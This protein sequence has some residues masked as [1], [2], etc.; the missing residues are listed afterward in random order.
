MIVDKHNLY[1]ERG[2]FISN[3]PLY[4]VTGSRFAGKP[5]TDNRLQKSP[6]ENREANE[7][8]TSLY[9]Y[10]NAPDG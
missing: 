3:W 7:K 5:V 2:R 1:K 8:I 9:A 6:P 10:P 4:Y